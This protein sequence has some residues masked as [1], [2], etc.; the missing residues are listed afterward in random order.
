MV[1][2]LLYEP[3]P[4]RS[5]IE[6]GCTHVL[7]LRSYPDGRRMPQGYLGLFERLVAPKCLD[8]FP[9][10]KDYMISLKHSERYSEDILQLN[11][12]VAPALASDGQA[13]E[14][15]ALASGVIDLGSLAAWLEAHK[16][17]LQRAPGGTL[18]ALQAANNET[19]VVQPV[20]DAVALA[21]TYG[22]LVHVDAVQAVGRL[23][24]DFAASKSSFLAI[25]GHKLGGP[26]GI[27]A[28]VVRSGAPLPPRVIGGGQE[29]GMRAGTENVAAIAG[30]GA[31]AAA[32]AG[33]IGYFA[34]LGGL[35]DRIEAGVIQASPGAVV[36]AQDSERL[37]NTTCLALPG[38]TAETLV[39]AFDLTG[40]AVSAG[41]ACS[42]GKV[43]ASPVLAAMGLSRD[44]ARGAIRISIGPATTVE[45][46]DAFVA[47]WVR[48]TRR[49]AQ[50]A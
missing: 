22:V 50:A 42:S 27:G 49:A 8:P 47:A 24:T 13:V 9:R 15:P 32:A 30:F 7:V 1:D 39:A 18:L 37:P 28:L 17:T 33:E 6:Q 40:V 36:I 48:I 3:I 26:K 19:G 20:A 2:A 25:S 38:R 23:P 29:R 10:V 45:D 14:L 5:A 16:E 41:A 4:Y 11:E 21:A 43:Q 35:R 31:A 46:I 34:A 12:G 44:I